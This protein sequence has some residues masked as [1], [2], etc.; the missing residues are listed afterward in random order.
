MTVLLI[1]KKSTNVSLWLKTNGELKTVQIMVILSVLQSKE[2][3]AQVCG[4]VILLMNSL[5]VYSPTT[6]PM[7]I[8]LLTKKT[9]WILI[10]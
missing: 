8:W 10:T 5:L 7:M 9:K 6:L 3:S 1:K 4:L 2:K